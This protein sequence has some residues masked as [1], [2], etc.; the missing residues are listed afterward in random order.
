MLRLALAVLL[1]VQGAGCATTGKPAAAA[2]THHFETL[3]SGMRVLVY[4]QPAARGASLYVSYRVGAAD[5]PPGQEGL[6]QLTQLLTFMARPE[7]PESPRLGER[8]SVIGAVFLPALDYDETAF[9]A[10]SAPLQ[11]QRLLELEAQRMREPLA[12]VTEADFLEAREHYL[13]TLRS[14]ARA[15]LAADMLRR[16]LLPGHPY[17]RPLAGTEAALARLTLEDA[18]AWARTHFTPDRAVLV[19]TSA[20]PPVDVARVV[21]ASF[22]ALA[23]GPAAAPVPRT[24][25]P[26]PELALPGRLVV[27]Q[28]DVDGPQLWLAWRA[29]GRYSGQYAET[30]VLGENLRTLIFPALVQA[31]PRPLLR[32]SSMGAWDMDGVTLLYATIE[33]ERAEDAEKVLAALNAQMAR[34]WGTVVANITAEALQKQVVAKAT[35]TAELLP[36]SAVA[37]YLRATGRADFPIAWPQQRRDT[38]LHDLRTAAKAHAFPNRTY[39]LLLTPRSARPAGA[40]GR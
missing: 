9:F 18:R 28:V 27:R 37:N 2:Y 12:E 11:L 39:G 7:G 24:P 13:A 8:L 4:G 34:F 5:E 33:L 31:A 35:Q 1:L 22:G 25:L 32:R 17:G 20:L 6:A 16:D 10:Q 36:P 26:L 40:A 38:L 21:T 30:I 3:P 23:A 29:P 19:V 15:H 14:H